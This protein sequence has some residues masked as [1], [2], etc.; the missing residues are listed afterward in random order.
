MARETTMTSV[1]AVNLT[2]NGRRVQAAAGQTV[3]EAAETAGIR[4]PTLCHHPR[5]PPQGSCRLCLVEIEK[6]RTL[7]P[8]CT[9]PVSDGMVI[10]TESEKVVAA[11]KF[12]LELL[13]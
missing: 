1:A 12:V 13:F 6:Q 7:Q 8:A 11:R 3:L 2:I 4:I 10:Q 9:F 5:L